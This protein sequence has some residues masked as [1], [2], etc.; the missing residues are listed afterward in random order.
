MAVKP[1]SPRPSRQAKPEAT[2]K[3]LHRSPAAAM[4]PADIEYKASHA[5]SPAQRRAS[6]SPAVKRHAPVPIP[7][8]A[9]VPP[10]AAKDPDYRYQLRPNGMLDSDGDGMPDEWEVK[11][12]LNPNDPHDARMDFD[13]DG[14]NALQ[15]Y[16]EGTNPRKPELTPVSGARRQPPAPSAPSPKSSR[17][18]RKGLD[19]PDPSSEG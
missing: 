18:R 19:C 6:V 11:H 1:R 8:A 3:T 16:R 10:V 12:G 4:G 13:K 17:K 7:S 2:L 9:P 15:E 5:K 14:R